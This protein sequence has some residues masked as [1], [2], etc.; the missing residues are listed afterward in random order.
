M[1]V[2]RLKFRGWAF[3]NNVIGQ[4]GSINRPIKGSNHS[5]PTRSKKNGKH[6]LPP[7]LSKLR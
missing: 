5:G 6:W 7:L 1:I 4:E 2:L 3:D